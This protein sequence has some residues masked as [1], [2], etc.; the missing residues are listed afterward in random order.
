MALFLAFF[1]LLGGKEGR[2]FTLT[3]RL[4]LHPNS[5]SLRPHHLTSY[6]SLSL[7][8]PPSIESMLN[9][10]ARSLSP[11]MLFPARPPAPL[12]LLY[13][14]ITHPSF[15]LRFFSFSLPFSFFLSFPIFFFTFFPSSFLSLY[16]VTDQGERIS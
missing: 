16:P 14:L 4:N 6:Y 10:L 12:R 15:I 1:L 5:P 2:K 7:S 8:V 11:F 9:C 13:L 3:A